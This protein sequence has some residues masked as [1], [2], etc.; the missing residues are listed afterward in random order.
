MEKFC[1][2]FGHG[3]TPQSAYPKIVNAISLIYTQEGVHSF[4]VGNYGNFD[5]LAKEA[6]KDFKKHHPEIIVQLLTPYH[7]STYSVICPKEFDGT[8]YPDNME[9][10]PR[11]FAIVKANQFT[12]RDCSHII[13][14]VNH[15]G[16]TNKLLDYAESQSKKVKKW[17][18]NC[19]YDDKETDCND[20][21]L[22]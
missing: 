20:I 11:R 17:I 21:L 6:L 16:N 8:Y 4:L 10:V 18:K 14:F 9:T 22:S 19:A 7:P 15:G 1:F 3:D 12:V 2:L 5:Y 13:C